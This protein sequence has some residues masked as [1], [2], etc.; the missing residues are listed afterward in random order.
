MGTCVLSFTIKL[1]DKKNNS[2][3]TFR[4]QLLEGF[5][6]FLRS[7]MYSMFK[8]SAFV[9]ECVE[10]KKL[11]KTKT[12]TRSINSYKREVVKLNILKTVPYAL[13]YCFLG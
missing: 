4:N 10:K 11:V 6:A 1:E 13:L 7:F 3:S 9:Y 12:S 2:K 5:N 8:Q